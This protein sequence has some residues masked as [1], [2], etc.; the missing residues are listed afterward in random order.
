[1]S[2]FFRHCTLTCRLRADSPLVFARLV[3]GDPPESR[4]VRTF[5]IKMDDAPPLSQTE[6][7]LVDPGT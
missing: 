6:V 2:C 1:M 7:K 5:D 4:H 3:A